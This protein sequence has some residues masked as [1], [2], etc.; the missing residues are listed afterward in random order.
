MDSIV[1][2]A[3]QRANYI[4]GGK[5]GEGTKTILLMLQ[6]EC[7]RIHEMLCNE[8]ILWETIS[9]MSTAMLKI[10]LGTLDHID[11]SSGHILGKK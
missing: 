4:K 3:L 7:Q 9:G 11:T 5:E 10:S 8:N 6:N 1:S 2:R